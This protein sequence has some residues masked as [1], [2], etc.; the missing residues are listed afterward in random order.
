MSQEHQLARHITVSD[1]HRSLCV[2]LCI[3]VAND[4]AY[5]HIREVSQKVAVPDHLP[6]ELHFLILI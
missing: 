5:N 1:D 3:K 4:L 6:S 2:P